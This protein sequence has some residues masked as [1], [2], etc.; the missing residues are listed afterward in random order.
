[1]SNEMMMFGRA[2]LVKGTHMVHFFE[3]SWWLATPPT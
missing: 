3:G 1:M 2:P